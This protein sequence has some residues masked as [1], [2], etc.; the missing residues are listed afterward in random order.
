MTD[1]VFP[2]RHVYR[3][4]ETESVSTDY[5]VIYKAQ[6]LLLQKDVCIKEVRISGTNRDDIE[7]NLQAARREARTMCRVSE[8]TSFV[9]AIHLTYFDKNQQKFF[10]IMDWVPGKTLDKYIE[11][12]PAHAKE[13]EFLTWIEEL[14]DILAV[15]AEQKVYHKDIKPANIII[16][17]KRRLHLLDFSISSSLPNKIEGTAY[18]KA[19]EMENASTVKRDKADIFSI[20]VIMY[21]YYCRKIP[22][23]GVEYGQQ[24][25]RRNNPD[26]DKFVSPKELNPKV[27]NRINN[28]ILNCMQKNPAERM[29]VIQLKKLISDAKS[30]VGR[31]GKEE[32]RRDTKRSFEAGNK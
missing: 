11:D 22:Q 16:D 21:Q 18:Y 29:N 24:S 15:M 27:T 31:H 32:Q 1:F 19:P 8:K 6:D 2:I 9:P 23:K 7:R 4:Y 13:H 30:E 20:G 17:K 25:I 3:P 5:S 28:I 10:I 14:C 12:G 26:W